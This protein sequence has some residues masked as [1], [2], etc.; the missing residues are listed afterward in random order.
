[1]MAAEAEA[2]RVEWVAVCDEF[3]NYANSSFAKAYSEGRSF[4]ICM[5]A[6]TQFLGA[7]PED[8][9]A[10]ILANANTLICFRLGEE[11]AGL[12]GRRFEPQ[13]SRAQLIDL[14]NFLAA[15]RT[16]VNGERL[17][18][19]TMK[20]RPPS[21]PWNREV[22]D[23]IREASHVRSPEIEPMLNV[24]PLSPIGSP[25]RKQRSGRPAL[26]A[27]PDIEEEEA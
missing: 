18:P 11:D 1:M 2:T 14:D 4:G 8:V 19:F 3:Q 16:S 24:V 10:A 27:W 6:C 7:V 13:V 25:G 12:I 20:V 17:P 26:Q 23:R 15:V 22:A 5:V 9:R 21:S